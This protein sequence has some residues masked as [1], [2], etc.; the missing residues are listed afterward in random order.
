M[1]VTGNNASTVMKYSGHKTLGSFSNYIYPTD[2]GRIVSMQA[3]DNVVGMLTAQ[4][5]VERVASFL[6]I[7][8]RIPARSSFGRIESCTG[9][10]TANALPDCSSL[11]FSPRNPAALDRH[12]PNK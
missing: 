9:L 1:K 4:G 11:A 7:G 8:V 2:E 5:C 6:N 10:I 3:L 12:S